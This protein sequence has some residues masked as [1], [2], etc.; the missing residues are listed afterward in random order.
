[1]TATLG[2]NGRVNETWGI[3]VKLEM[4]SLAADFFNQILLFLAYVGSS[5]V[6][7]GSNLS[8]HAADG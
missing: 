3:A 5:I 2:I 6:K 8:S 7:T 1:M 4:T